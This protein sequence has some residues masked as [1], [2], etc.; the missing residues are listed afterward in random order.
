M[1]SSCDLWREAAPK[2]YEIL[3][4]GFSILGVELTIGKVLSDNPVEIHILSLEA[5]RTNQHRGEILCKGYE[6]K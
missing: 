2:K 1:F 4:A 6:P 3:F 5:R